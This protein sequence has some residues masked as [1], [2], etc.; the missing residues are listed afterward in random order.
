M[1]GLPG[2]TD[3]KA[4]QGLLVGGAVFE[5]FEVNVGVVGWLEVKAGVSL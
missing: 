3:E 5:D 4:Q 1:E 2:E